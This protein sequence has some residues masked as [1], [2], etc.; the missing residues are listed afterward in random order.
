M[1]SHVPEVTVPRADGPAARESLTI[2]IT[3]FH[4]AE[5]LRALLDVLRDVVRDVTVARPEITTGL[6]VVDND[7]AGSGRPA[8]GANG[9]ARY[10]IEPRPGIAAAR[11]RALDEAGTDLLV[12]IDDDEL[13]EPG[14]LDALLDTRTRFAA[15]AVA[16]RVVTRFHEDIDPWI[17]AGGFLDRSFRDDVATGGAL[18]SAATNNLLLDLRT[19]RRLGLRF[20]EAF[21][22]SG[23]ED[24]MFT[25]LFVRRGARLV[26]CAE[27][28][29][30]DVLSPD[31]HN[32][33]WM[34]RRSFGFGTNEAR[35]AIT[36]AGSGRSRLALRL[37]LCAG[38]C[39]RLAL[40]VT[41]HLYGRLT[42]NL[43]K[44]VT[45]LRVC[46]RGLGRILGSV[47]YTHRA[48]GG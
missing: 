47:G 28:V 14:W 38:G 34:L 31:R 29:V 45:G 3:T 43:T 4:R 20:D 32:R 39:A 42:G 21:G 27:A 19:V 5:Q 1:P 12:F 7:P 15:D 26:W 30:V 18:S 22:I 46:A 24:S 36:L 23:G 40:G 13:P 41:W 2:A 16:G 17:A 35:I 48:Y 6:L 10:V 11:N 33:R 25:S 9:A 37:S 8:L 44:R